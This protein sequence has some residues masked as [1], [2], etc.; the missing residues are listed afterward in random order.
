MA[1]LWYYTKNGQ[2]Q[3]PVSGGALRSLATAGTLRAS[4]LVWKEGMAEWVQAGTIKGLF[5]GSAAGETEGYRSTRAQPAGVPVAA[6]LDDNPPRRRGGRVD[7]DEPLDERPRRRRRRDAEGELD[8]RPQRRRPADDED[9]DDFD[10]R[11]RRRRRTDDEDDFLPRRRRR[12][13]MSAGAKIAI[14]G[15]ACALVVVVVAGIL[16]IALVGGGNT[17]SFNLQT[18]QKTHFNLR[19]TKGKTVEIW[20]KSNGVSD[21]DLFVFDASNRLIAQDEDFSKDCFVR[22]V[23]AATQTYKVEVWNRL[24]DARDFRMRNEAMMRNGPNSGTVIF[25]ES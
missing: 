14:I 11:P 17:R 1:D 15:G 19:F 20:V 23:P 4:D 6:E 10:D 5:S 2:Q 12:A 13:G 16:I 9:D 18:N 3:Q 21:V 25:K 8:E 7:D 24:L 22:F